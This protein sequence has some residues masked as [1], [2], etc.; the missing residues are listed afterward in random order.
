MR[1]CLD[2]KIYL[3]TEIENNVFHNY[4]LVTYACPK[5]IPVDNSRALCKTCNK[6]F[7]ISNGG[8]NDVKII[9]PAHG[10]NNCTN[11]LVKIGGCLHL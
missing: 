3:F 1:W 6:L 5:K 10:I 9:L 11:W 8:E 2:E 7:T 4:M